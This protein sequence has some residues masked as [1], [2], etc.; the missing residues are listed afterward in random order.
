MAEG[1]KWGKGWKMTVVA[2]DWE[3]GSESASGKF[4]G[5]GSG[6]AGFSVSAD[7]ERDVAEVRSISYMQYLCLDPG[8]APEPGAGGQR[9]STQMRGRPSFTQGRI[10]QP[11]GSTAGPGLATLR[12]KGSGGTSCPGLRAD[13]L[14]VNYT[15]Q[16]L[17]A[18]PAIQ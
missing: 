14:Y 17:Q 13:V 16:V 9:V 1:G 4:G 6:K 3:G 18:E 10:M 12:L 11:C 8:A 2:P 15:C 5:G 7:F